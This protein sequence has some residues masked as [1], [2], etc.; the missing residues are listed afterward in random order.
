MALK[1][2]ITAAVGAHGLW[3][4]RLRTAIQTGKCEV[5]PQAVSVDNQCKFGQWLY[6][7]SL[8]PAEKA[9]PGYRE[10]RDLHA[11]FHRSAAGVLELALGG[12]TA[13]AEA[14]MKDGSEFAKVSSTLT[15]AMLR[16]QKQVG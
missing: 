1:E 9:S 8:T 6:G 15:D 16:W 10:C 7:V 12:H 14:A 3:K 2:E 13:Q 5:T 11:R 4:T